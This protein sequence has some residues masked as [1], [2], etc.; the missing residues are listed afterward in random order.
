M[1]KNQKIWLF[2]IVAFTSVFF[3]LKPVLAPFL[4][5]AFLAYLGDPLVN[6]LMQL[7]LSR[8]SAA[9]LVFVIIMLLV[10]ALFLFLIPLI[11]KQFGVFIGRL[12]Q[13]LLWL[14]AVALPWLDKHLDLNISLDPQV[15]KTLLAEHWQQAGNLAITVWQTLS[16]SG[17]AIIGWLAKVLIVPVVTF[18]LLCD[19]HK[20]VSGARNLLP[21][22]IEPTVMQL[23]WECNEVVS[24]FLRGQFLVMLVLAL[25]YWIGLAAIGL[26]LALM[27]GVLAG[28]FSIVPY[29]GL[30]IGILSASIAAVVQF[31]D[32]THVIYVLIVFTVGHLIESFA[33]VPLF[34]GDRIGLHPVAVIF[35]IFAGGH[36][37]GF[38]G[39]LLALPVAAVLMILLRHGKHHY[40]QSEIYKQ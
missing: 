33:L 3:L 4:F 39:V 26:D 29:L 31:H 2:S 14:Q 37:F 21:R 16:Q 17:I 40:M 30:I 9:V 13:F 12:P 8:V 19:W 27:L 32:A 25:I 23:W 5:A 34:V 1:T 10:V 7:K 24:A 20:V 22:R 11:I 6:R 38:A 36:L 18:Y 35:A 28:L 15:F